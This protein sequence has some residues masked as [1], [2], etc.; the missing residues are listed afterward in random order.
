MYANIKLI[1]FFSVKLVN[2]NDIN[3]I[4][5]NKN[6]RKISIDNYLLSI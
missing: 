4:I 2:Y 3:I 5:Y 1:L 6:N